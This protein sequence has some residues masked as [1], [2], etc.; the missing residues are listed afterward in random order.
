MAR[1]LLTRVGLDTTRLLGIGVDNASVNTG[2]NNGVF[3][4][5]TLENVDFLVRETHTWFCHSSKRKAAYSK[6]YKS[7]CDGDNPLAIPR[8]CDTRWISLEPAVARMF[9]DPLNKLY[10]LYLRPILREVQRAN[11]AY[12]R[13]D[14]DSSRLLEDPKP[15]LEYEFEKLA[16][17][18][19]AGPEVDLVLQCC[20]AFT[21]KPSTELRLRLPSNYKILQAMTRLSVGA[22]L[23]VLKEPIVELAELFGVHPN[24]IDAQ[25]R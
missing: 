10:L 8:V 4:T 25:D 14:A 7:L 17:T 24:K 15:Y 6:L 20:I 19:P 18:L 22:C 5:M 1:L 12:E 9:S 11:K 21:V 16:N 2:V 13:N 23:R 3:E